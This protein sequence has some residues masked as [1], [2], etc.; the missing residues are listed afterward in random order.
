VLTHVSARYSHNAAVLRREARTVFDRTVVAR[1]G[2][3]V[4]VPH[5][6]AAAGGAPIAVDDR[7]TE[8]G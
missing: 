3:R 5:R 2:L 1:D 4:D 7:P 8:L 6:D